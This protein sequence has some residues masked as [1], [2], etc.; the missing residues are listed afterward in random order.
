MLSEEDQNSVVICTKYLVLLEG[1]RFLMLQIL[2]RI[3][4]I[5]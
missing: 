3:E 1:F 2:S 4:V 5:S